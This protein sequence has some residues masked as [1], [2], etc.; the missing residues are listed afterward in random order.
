MPV[1][2][3]TGRIELDATGRVVLSA[4]DF[5]VV[6]VPTITTVAPTTVL[7]PARITLSGS[8]LDGVREVRLNA[9]TLTIA[10]RTPTSLAVDVPSGAA[11]G[12]LTVVDTAG[13]A[14]PLSQPITVTGPLS[15]SSYSPA[16]I[17]TGQT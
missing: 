2:A 14:R 4:T 3:S 12:T 16:S 7:P 11:S 5:T 17:V 13:V 6:A 1:G 10:S 15:I 9:L 8:A